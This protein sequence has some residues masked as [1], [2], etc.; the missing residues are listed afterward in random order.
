MATMVIVDVAGDGFPSWMGHGDGFT[1]SSVH[2]ADW[3][4]PSFLFLSG[5]SSVL[6]M[7]RDERKGDGLWKILE[8]AAKLF[9]LGIVVQ[10]MA[11]DSSKLWAGLDLSSFRVMGICAISS[12]PFS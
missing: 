11:S 7:Q 5:F 6:S 9:S 1:A 8:R 3:V 4:M 10:E 2:I 12:A